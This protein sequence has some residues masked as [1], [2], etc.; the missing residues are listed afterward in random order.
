MGHGDEQRQPL[1]KKVE[2]LAGQR[3]AAVSAGGDHNIA[4][5]ADAAIVTWGKSETGCLGHGEDQPH[6]ML[7]KKVE[8]WG[9]G[10]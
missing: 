4:L 7:P 2:A 1:P 10:Q 9:L 3:V 6:Q 8:A 5:T